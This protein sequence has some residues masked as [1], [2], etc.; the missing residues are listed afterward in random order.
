MSDT[1]QETTIMTTGIATAFNKVR[2]AVSKKAASAD[3]EY[4]DWV[5]DVANEKFDVDELADYLDALECD[6]DAFQTDVETYSN[7]LAW[8]AQLA[9][10]PAATAKRA[11]IRRKVEDINRTRAAEIDAVNEKHDAAVLALNPDEVAATTAIR[12]AEVA[13]QR[14]VQTAT[15][16]MVERLTEAVRKE[17]K[18]R[19][20]RD[21]IQTLVRELPA[22]LAAWERRKTEVESEPTWRLGGDFPSP[23]RAGTTL[24]EVEVAQWEAGP[25]RTAQ[26]AGI[27]RAIATTKEDAERYTSRLADLEDQLRAATAEV[28]AARAE[29]LKP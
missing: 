1:Q 16:A 6:L 25:T 22:K 10:G 5:I 24:S 23:P 27:V 12:D 9:A 28:S 18:I 19:T 21:K 3:K 17:T 7:R 14:L 8:A 15:P 13:E 2:S 29:L 11:E 20:E 26:L 4:R